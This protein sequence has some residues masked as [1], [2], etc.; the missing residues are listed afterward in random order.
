MTFKGQT[1]LL[2]LLSSPFCEKALFA[3]F[4]VRV[5]V[6]SRVSPVTSELVAPLRA[7]LEDFSNLAPYIA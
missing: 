7:V 6:T 3:D 4:A 1:Q 5:G 2:V